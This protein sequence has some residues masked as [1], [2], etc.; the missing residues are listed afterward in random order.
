MKK[1]EMMML[2]NTALESKFGIECY[3]SSISSFKQLF[4]T[5]RK[6]LRKMGVENVDSIALT[7][8]PLEPNEKVWLMKKEQENSE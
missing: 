7:L 8:S 3:T 5:T 1:Q 4:Y 6:E 2:I